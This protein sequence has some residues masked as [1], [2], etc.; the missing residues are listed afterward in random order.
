MTIS[1]KALTLVALWATLAL[2]A[3]FAVSSWWIRLLLLVV[4]VGVTIHLLKMR[5]HR[6]GAHADR[7][8][9]AGI[10]PPDA[11]EP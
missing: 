11:E 3:G 7:K 4:G 9:A 1:S 10:A 5:T 6:P 2:S 8:A